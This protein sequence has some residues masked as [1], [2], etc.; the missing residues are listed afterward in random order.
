MI[1]L[2]PNLD[3]ISVPKKLSEIFQGEFY[4]I[5][6]PGGRIGGQDSIDSLFAVPA[7]ESEHFERVE[8][9]PRIPAP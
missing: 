3:K 9:F 5:L 2:R 1:N 8:R 7:D 4:H 6:H